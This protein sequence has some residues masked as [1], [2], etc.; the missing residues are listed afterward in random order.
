M[1]KST[2]AKRMNSTGMPQ[3]AHPAKEPAG[4]EVAAH[5]GEQAKDRKQRHDWKEG[6]FTRSLRVQRVS[7]FNC[8]FG[9]VFYLAALGVTKRRTRIGADMV[10][11]TASARGVALALS[12]TFPTRSAHL[13]IRIP[14]KRRL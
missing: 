12:R 11:N 6:K 8:F 7:P 10:A 5:A 14:S 2:A 13:L 9:A 1:K 4:A 3:G